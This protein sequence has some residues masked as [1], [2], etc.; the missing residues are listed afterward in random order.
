MVQ[1][2]SFYKTLFSSVRECYEHDLYCDVKL[3]ACV[4]GND[5]NVEESADYPEPSNM[6]AVQCHS[7]VLCSVAPTFKVFF[8]LARAFSQPQP[9]QTCFFSFKKPCFIGYIYYRMYFWMLRLITNWKRG[10]FICPI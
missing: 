1:L 6:R 8:Y 10:V 7:L 4:E 5:S 9:R 3:F 2:S